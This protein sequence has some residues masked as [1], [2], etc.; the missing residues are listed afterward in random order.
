MR[1]NILANV[2]VILL[3]VILGAAAGLFYAWQIDPRV[4]TEVGP[5]QLAES[6]K[7]NYLI[8]ISLAYARDRRIEAAA[9]RL[10]ELG[11]TWQD[12]ADAACDLAT[13][14][15]AGSNTGLTAIK[16]M[17]ELAGSQ[18]Y[19]GCASALIPS[20]SATPRPSPTAFTP[21]PTLNIVPTKTATLPPEPSESPFPTPVPTSEGQFTLGNI[22][23]FCDPRFP[24]VIEVSVLD[25]NGDGIPG[26]AVRVSWDGGSA[27]LFTGLKPERNIGFADFVMTEGINYRVQLVEGGEVTRPLEASACTAQGGVQARTSYRVLFQ[28]T[29]R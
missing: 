2:I 5:A 1:S 21:T 7:R 19:R 14:G 22:V 23:P 8:L 17:V 26:I 4:V 28:R 29:Q 27:R 13:S 6:E 3:G 11:K 25:R 12:V 10:L 24:G 16:S 15:Y 9:E 18:G 20:E